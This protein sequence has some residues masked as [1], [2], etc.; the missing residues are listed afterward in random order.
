MARAQG[1]S[2]SELSDTMILCETIFPYIQGTLGIP[3]AQ[4][5]EEIGKSNFRDLTAVLRAIISG[6]PSGSQSVNETVTRLLNDTAATLEAS[7][8]P[9]DEDTVRRNTVEELLEAGAL[10]NRELRE[11]IRPNRT[12]PVAPAVFQN[13]ANRILVMDVSEDQWEM[14]NNRLRGYM[15]PRIV[16]LPADQRQRQREALSIASV[17][18]IAEIVSD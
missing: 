16:T 12:P 18:R 10:P 6:A 5:W 14:L 4:I 13:G 17:R 9:A 2:V 11:R 8:Q 3:V 15:D 1:I 7:G